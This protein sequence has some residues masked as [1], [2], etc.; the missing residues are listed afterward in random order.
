[1]KPSPHRFYFALILLLTMAPN[2]HAY[3]DP[4]SGMILI[5]AAVA[6]IIAAIGA[7]TKPIKTF[8]RF[9]S[10]LKDRDARP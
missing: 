3:I 6:I 9:L 1:M 4:G 2:A 10:K 5:Q 7:V 8:K